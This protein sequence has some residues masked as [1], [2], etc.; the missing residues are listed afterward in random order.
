MKGSLMKIK[1]PLNNYYSL[2]NSS[3]LPNEKNVTY[4]SGIFCN[5]SFRKDKGE[6]KKGSLVIF[7]EVDLLVDSSCLFSSNK[8]I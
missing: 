6:R 7:H 8:P 2:S 1:I 4:V 3:D 5:L